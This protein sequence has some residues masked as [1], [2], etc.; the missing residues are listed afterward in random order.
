MWGT[1]KVTKNK[2]SQCLYTKKGFLILTSIIGAF[3]INT[4]NVFIR[5]LNQN[6]NAYGPWLKATTTIKRLKQSRG[7]DRWDIEPINQI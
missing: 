2:T 1:K 4:R 7:K 3:V 6:M 5:N